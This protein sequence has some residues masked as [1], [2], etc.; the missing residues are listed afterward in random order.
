[1]NRCFTQLR[2]SSVLFLNCTG[3][4]ESA[5]FITTPSKNV[6]PSLRFAALTLW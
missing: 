5:R 3:Y 4:I 6:A 1:M 2:H